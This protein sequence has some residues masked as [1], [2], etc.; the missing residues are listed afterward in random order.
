[1]RRVAN[2]RV[3]LYDVFGIGL[4]IGARDQIGAEGDLLG[5][6]PLGRETGNACPDSRQL[7]DNDAQ[8]RARRGVV[9]ANEL[10]SLFDALPF[11]D[12]DRTDDPACRVLH[13]LDIRLHYD[14][15]LG[16]DSGV[17]AGHDA[18]RGC[19]AAQQANGGD[20]NPQLP[21][22]R[23]FRIEHDV[24]LPE[25]QLRAMSLRAPG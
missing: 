24:E 23:T 5:A 25:T 1:M 18:P 6:V 13:L 3:A 16:H 2:T 14:R 17:Q 12:M 15:S 10:V 7:V 21:S 4:G 9:E 22:N 8:R 20:A 11:P 19:G